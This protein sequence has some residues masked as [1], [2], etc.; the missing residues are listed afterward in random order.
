MALLD[1]QQA[2]HREDSTRISAIIMFALMLPF[3]LGG[4]VMGWLADRLPRKWIM[5]FA[6][7]A[8]FALMLSMPMIFAGMFH[9][10]ADTSWQL[11]PGTEGHPPILN[12]WAYALPLFV[13]GCFAAMFSPA[14]AAMLPTLI[15]TDQIVRANGLM[16]AMGPIATIA[17]F[18]IG[19]ELVT[20]YGANVNFQVDAFTFLA[21]AGLIFCIIPPRRIPA[22]RNATAPQPNRLRDGLAYC[23]THRRVIELILLA[24]LFWSAAGVIR[25]IIPALVGHVFGG[26]TRAIGY[27]QATL[28][29]GMLCGAGLLAAFG[30][31]L[32]SEFAITWSLLG[33]GLAA[34]WM[35]GVASLGLSR[36][37]GYAGLLFIGMFGS[38][39]L[40]SVNAL[41]QKIVPDL[42]RGRVFGVMDVAT[43]AGLLLAT[44]VLAIPEWPN[45]DRYVPSLL[46]GVGLLILTGGILSLV[47]RL[48]RGRFGFTITFWRNVAEFYMRLTARVRREGYRAIPLSGPVILAAN[49]SCSI[50][51]LLLVATLPNRCPGFMIAREYARIPIFSRLVRMIGCIP[52]N[53]TGVDT[54]S[55]KAALRHLAE[56][57][58][59]GIFPQG[60]IRR[61]DEQTTVQEGI[62]LL[63]LRSGATIIPAHISGVHY[64]DNVVV[65]FLRRHRAI[66]RYGPPVN[67]SAWQGREK[68]R[69]AYREVAEYVMANINALAPNQD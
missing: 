59:L 38:G 35:A 30:D 42:F 15:R 54:A 56:G 45:I 19:G 39:I 48:R 44:G 43:M 61:P 41:L 51:P 11:K 24:L 14:R 22:L 33:A 68:E 57:R 26:D 1:M 32:R 8:R 67:L 63:A 52:V 47:I 46:L 58:M 16:N 5:I 29:I 7:L 13:T 53:R 12:P 40:V 9:G 49:H 62:G 31:A 17:S 6:D 27:Y 34:C 21:S 36:S 10:L 23:A 55:V 66:V 3:F 60:G 18:L 65:P 28:G 20:R 64:S 50:D 69:A 25:S 2:T 37:C 4:P